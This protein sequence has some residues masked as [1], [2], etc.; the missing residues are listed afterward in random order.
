MY[1]LKSPNMVDYLKYSN[2]EYLKSSNIEYLK[3]SNADRNM[4]YLITHGLTTLDLTVDEEVKSYNLSFWLKIF[5]AI[6][7]DSYINPLPRKIVKK[8]YLNIVQ[9]DTDFVV[10]INDHDSLRRVGDKIYYTY[11]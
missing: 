7:D 8:F 4:G 1:Y 3:S 10:S 2:I 9:T 6:T 11:R 5:T